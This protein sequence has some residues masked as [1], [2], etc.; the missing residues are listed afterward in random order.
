M[1][2]YYYIMHWYKFELPEC[3][4]LSV[5]L[6]QT[7]VRTRCNTLSPVSACQLRW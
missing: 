2:K 7:S 5:W 6:P 4:V 3:T 1:I